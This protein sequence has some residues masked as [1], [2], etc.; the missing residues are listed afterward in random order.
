MRRRD[1]RK[2]APNYQLALAMSAPQLSTEQELALAR[3]FRE[4]QDRDAAESLTRANLRAVTALAV[5]Y[6]HYGVPIADLVAEGNCGLVHALGKFDPERGVRFASYAVHWVRAYILA[7]VLRS[8]SI[9]SGASG[10]LR[11]QLY[12]RIKRER[13]RLT[14]LLGD[15]EACE[16]AIAERLQLSPKRV[17]SLLQRLDASD[18]SL[19]AP[20][21]G[22]STTSLLDELAE[23]ANPEQMLWESSR[24]GSVDAAMREALRCLDA[25]E[26]YIVEHRLLAD[27]DQELSLAQLG[28][29]FDISR[30]R[31]RQIET[32]AK[33]KLQERVTARADPA[34]IDWLSPP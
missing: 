9:V 15:G 21:R 2:L 8:A 32:R 29:R 23:T 12:F 18:V 16:R 19:D 31:V 28:R 1:E 11:S 4:H 17:K 7:H 24:R 22:D 25:R 10:P 13:A 27:S 33:R 3:S 34:L 20:R 30:E 26:R 6:R 14:N 5:K